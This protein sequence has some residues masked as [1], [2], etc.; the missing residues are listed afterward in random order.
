M[1]WRYSKLC[2]EVVTK[3]SGNEKQ[4]VKIF[5]IGFFKISLHAQHLNTFP[6]KIGNGQVPSSTGEGKESD[7][8]SP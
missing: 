5:V 3:D 8:P 2:V 7:I 6:P 4:L 1:L